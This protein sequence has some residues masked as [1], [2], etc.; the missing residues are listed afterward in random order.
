[1]LYNMGVRAL[2]RRR[3]LNPLV[4][5]DRAFLFLFSLLMIAAGV[6]AAVWL[7]ATGQAA[8]VDGLFLMLTAL[9][10][11][12]CFALYV[13]FLI[14]R[15]MEP[16]ARSAQPARSGAAQAKAAAGKTEPAH[17]AQP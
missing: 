2:P 8:T 7:V 17:V 11:A 13:V 14:R 4:M 10:I 9:L 15:A 5:P 16:A 3:E 12:L 1:L 6:A